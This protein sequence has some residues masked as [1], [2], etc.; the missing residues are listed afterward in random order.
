MPK[1]FSRATRNI[2]SAR[3]VCRSIVRQGPL[4]PSVRRSVEKSGNDLRC[5]VRLFVPSTGKQL[6][7]CS[8][9]EQKETKEKKKNEKKYAGITCSKGKR[10]RSRFLVKCPVNAAISVNRE[11]DSW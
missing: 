2:P 1:R 9:F 10:E 7:D 5:L 3:R 8:F 11:A 6:R 4:V